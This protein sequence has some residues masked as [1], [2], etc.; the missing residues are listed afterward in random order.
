[1]IIPWQRRDRL[2][3]SETQPSEY[4]MAQSIT[5]LSAIVGGKKTKVLVPLSND[6]NPLVY[7]DKLPIYAVRVK[8]GTSPETVAFIKDVFGMF[9]RCFGV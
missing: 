1:M 9:S 3:V 6:E 7:N 2:R 8:K 5:Y 4:F